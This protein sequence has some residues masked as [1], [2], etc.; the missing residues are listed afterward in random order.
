[1]SQPLSVC[2][3]EVDLVLIQ[4]SF[5]FLWKLCLKNT[6]L[7]KENL[8]YII[9]Q[10]GLYQN[11]VN[12][13]LQCR[14]ILG[15]RNVVRV[16]IRHL[17]FYDSGRLGRVEIVNLTVGVRAPPPHSLWLVPFPPLFG[18]FQHGAF[19]SK[20]RAQRKRLHCRLGQLQPRFH[21]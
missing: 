2:E 8:I 14:R 11:K 19:T 12:S 15:G 16:C 21:Q 10:E 1:M 7:H 6:S 13:S 4:T 3:A 17:W 18:K 9:K 5:L 20:L